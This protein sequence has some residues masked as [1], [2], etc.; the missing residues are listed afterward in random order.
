MCV[1]CQAH[2]GNFPTILPMVGSKPGPALFRPPFNMMILMM[3]KMLMMMIMMM[4]MRM[5]MMMMMMMMAM[6]MVM[7]TTMMIMRQKMATLVM[8][9]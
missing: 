7:V 8:D 2:H 6:M 9:T 1:C 5:M 4:M 3:I